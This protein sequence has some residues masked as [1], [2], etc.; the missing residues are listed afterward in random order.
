[1]NRRVAVAGV[2][3][4]DVGSTPSATSYGLIAQASRRAVAEA[5]PAH[6]RLTLQHAPPRDPAE[7][8]PFAFGAEMLF[9]LQPDRL[10]VTL[11]VTNEDRCAWPAG[12]GLHPYV[13]RTPAAVLRFEADTLWTTDAHS[14][15]ARRV[16]VQGENEFALGRPLG[17]TEIDACYAGWGGAARVTMPEAGIALTLSAEPPMDH[18]QLYTPA[19]RDYL[20]LEPVT[21][22]PDAINRM[23]TDAD[24]G[25]RVLA[26]GDRLQA[27]VTMI[28]GAA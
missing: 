3:L 1:M 27:V 7:Q 11:S 10:R 15:P 14:L 8:W 28:V 5:G 16:P 25:L 26:P 23:Q 6:A 9:D 19:G 17:A 24:Q 18:L 2:A 4:S 21:N 12:L 13:A 20:G 22:M